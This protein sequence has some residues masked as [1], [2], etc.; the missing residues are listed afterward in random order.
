M[1]QAPIKIDED[2]R[3]VSANFP[4]FN[5]GRQNLWLLR[6]LT[7]LQRAPSV[8]QDVSIQNLRIP[9]PDSK[10]RLRLR[11]YKPKFARSARPVLVW[12]HG[13]GYVIGRPEMDDPCCTAFVLET[14]VAVVSVDY[15]LAPEHPFPAGLEDGYAALKWV[16]AHAAELGVDAARLAVGGE[17]A[18]GGLAAGLAQLACD[19]REVTPI[20]Q[21]LV[22][23]ML[24][25]RTC[26][27]PETDFS[28]I[29][30]WTQGSNRFGWESYLGQKWG[31][32]A[33]P[34][35]STP[36][37]RENLSGLPPAWIGVGTL[38]LF[39][40]EDLAYAQRL[41]DCGVECEVKR[42]PG[43]FHG[44]D[45]MAPRAGVTRDFRKAQALA[46]GKYLVTP[47]GHKFSAADLMPGLSYRVAVAFRDYD[48]TLHPAGE[49]WRFVSKSFL[50]YDDGLTLWLNRGGQDGQL[51]LQWRPEAQAQ[52]IEHFSEFIEAV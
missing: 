48:G 13:G 52:V 32:A 29:L 43:A 25:D 22:Y 35:Y 38:D 15:R 34:P 47:R 23:P 12:F 14:G 27:R 42:V 30:V 51:R 20:F 45:S 40:D 39:Q 41:K 36:A 49:S 19:R 11:V 9:G 33:L 3:R 6:L 1:S 28:N 46:L 16:Q 50:P 44:F 8:P 18:G 17:S 10:T 21:M 31:A 26:A 7:I 24:D 5:F 37:R 2:L 4:R